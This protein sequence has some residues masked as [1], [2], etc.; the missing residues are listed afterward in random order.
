MQTNSKQRII[1]VEGTDAPP[2]EDLYEQIDE[3]GGGWRISSAATTC[4][5]ITGRMTLNG[6]PYRRYVITAVLDIAA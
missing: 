3:L 5:T 2:I 6:R 4:E 1:I